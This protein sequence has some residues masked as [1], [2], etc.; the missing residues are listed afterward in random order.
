MARTHDVWSNGKQVR[1]LTPY[2]GDNGL[3]SIRRFYADNNGS[4]RT[5]D[6]FID[7][8]ATDKIDGLSYTTRMFLR[9]GGKELWDMELTTGQAKSIIARFRQSESKHG[10][11]HYGKVEC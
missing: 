10:F 5:F 11:T 9:C 2:M 6:E 7:L 1:I 3:A 4:N 8:Y